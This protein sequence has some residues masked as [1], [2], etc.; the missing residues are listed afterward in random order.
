[1]GFI[2]TAKEA[3]IMLEKLSEKFHAWAKGWRVIILFIADALMMGYV[4]PV[5][6]GIMALAANNSVLPLDLMFFYTPDKAF[7][8]LEKYGAAG[9][10]IYLKIE[11]TADIIYPIIYTLFYA[12]LISWLFQRG[13]KS[14]SPMQK[15]N[16]MPMGAWL[17]DLLENVGAVSMVSMYPAQSPILAWITMLIGTLK[18]AFALVSI[19]LILVGLVRA[20]LNGF[21]K[22]E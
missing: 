22:Q 14:D 10:A 3:F 12:L 2:K 13:F 20:A 15:W 5:A 7:D 21:R 11:L 17:F 18:W 16:V 6:A 19:G 9:R 1:V 8:M 4:M